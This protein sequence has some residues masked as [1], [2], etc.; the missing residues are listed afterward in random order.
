MAT[1]DAKRAFATLMALL[2]TAFGGHGMTPAQ[3]DVYWDCLRDLDVNALA[4][5]VRRIIQTRKYS[6]IPTIAEIREAVLGRDEDIETAAL[7]AWGE[8]TRAVGRGTYIADGGPIDEAIR[9][10]FGGWARFGETDMANEMADRKHFLAVYR[11]LAKRRR[12]MGDPALPAA[13]ETRRLG[14]GKERP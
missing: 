8:A 14:A 9:V 13:R 6:S 7:V 12:D 1:T 3:I 5:A 2:G 10:A 11:G 4:V